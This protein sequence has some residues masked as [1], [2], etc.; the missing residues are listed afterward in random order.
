MP[1]S[2]P[3]ASRLNRPSL[4]ASLHP[5]VPSMTLSSMH[6]PL[7]SPEKIHHT[8]TL[9]CHNTLTNRDRTLTTH[10][11]RISSGS[12]PIT[13]YSPLPSPPVI[14][15]ITPRDS[16]H[17][18]A[19]LQP[20]SLLLR[21]SATKIRHLPNK[22][23]RSTTRSIIFTPA[24][25]NHKPG[26]IY[27]LLVTPTQI[28]LENHPY[29][30]LNLA[31]LESATLSRSS[32]LLCIFP[33]S[34]QPTTLLHLGSHQFIFTLALSSLRNIHIQY[35]IKSVTLTHSSPHSHTMDSSSHSYIFEAR[36]LA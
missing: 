23:I 1:P 24:C 25:P 13:Y 22:I 15:I 5:H 4:L 20:S 31:S 3:T 9:S 26:P 7:K 36:Y 18:G 6:T 17:S 16:G 32:N 12:H 34:S 19:I 29:M 35:S 11:T 21:T 28:S 33:S 10:T 8:H 2:P 30:L 14:S 27:T